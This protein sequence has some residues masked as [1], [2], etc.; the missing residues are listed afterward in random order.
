[1]SAL[2]ASVNRMARVA[3]SNEL[4]TTE[5]TGSNILQSSEDAPLAALSLDA[6]ICLAL[7]RA[8][9]SHQEACLTMGVDQSLWT[10]QRNGTG[11]KGEDHVSFQRLQKLPA[12]FWRE[13]L[14]LLAS[15]LQLTMSHQD[16]ADFAMLKIAALVQEIG[17]YVIQVRAQQRKVA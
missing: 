13:F 9:I 2:P 3:S 11:K 8:G 12:K 14:P 1:M 4:R 17:I 5:N 10:K 15:P 16:F 7:D 6:A